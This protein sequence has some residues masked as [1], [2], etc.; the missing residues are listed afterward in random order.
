M[1]MVVAT[2]VMV[3]V[4][5]AVMVH[6][7]VCDAWDCRQ[8]QTDG[9]SGTQGES[10]LDDQKEGGKDSGPPLDHVSIISRAGGRKQ[11][12]FRCERLACPGIR[13]ARLKRAP[14]LFRSGIAVWVW[15]F[16]SSPP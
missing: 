6:G 3:P 2:I 8:W 1:V 7:V 9:S 5:V 4:M 15:R 14:A 13:G 11:D 16:P 10:A 12:R